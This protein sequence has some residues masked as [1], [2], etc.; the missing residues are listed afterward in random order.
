[1][2]EAKNMV[3]LFESILRDEERMLCFEQ[4]PIRYAI[5]MAVYDYVKVGNKLSEIPWFSSVNFGKGRSER[6]LDKAAA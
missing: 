3:N 4:D 6:R 1:M 5:F 2:E